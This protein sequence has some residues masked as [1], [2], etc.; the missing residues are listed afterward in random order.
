MDLTGMLSVSFK[1]LGDWRVDFIALA[2]IIT[3]AALRYVGSVYHRRPRPR[4]RPPASLSGAAKAGAASTKA[5]RAAAKSG[6]AEGSEEGSDSGMV[7]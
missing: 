7:E 1:V 2:V 4:P 3:W 6:R 5:G